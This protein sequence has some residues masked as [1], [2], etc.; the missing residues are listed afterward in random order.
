MK[1]LNYIITETEKITS[2]DPLD[3]DKTLNLPVMRML[4]STPIQIDANNTLVSNVLKSFSYDPES[5]T[6]HLKVQSDLTFSDGSP[7]RTRDIALAISRMISARP[8]F[9]VLKDI[10]GVEAWIKDTQELSTYPSG[11]SVGEKTIDIKLN[12]N[13][14]NPLFRFCLEIFSIIPEKC[15]DLKTN[16]LTCERP[17]S[18]GYYVIEKETENQISF[19]KRREGVSFSEHVDFEELIFQYKKM[20]NACSELISDNTLISG[21]EIG[22]ILSNCEKIKNNF[23]LHWTAAARFGFVLFS[24]KNPVFKKS[25]N[26]AYF[27]VKVREQLKKDHP[28]MLVTQSLFTSILPGFLNDQDFANDFSSVN[29]LDFKDQSFLY[30]E[31]VS[32]AN[33]VIHH[34]IIQTAESLGMKVKGIDAKF[35]SEKYETGESSVEMASSG[36]W[37]QDPVGDLSMFFTKNLHRPLLFVWNDETHYKLLNKIESTTDSKSIN[38]DMKMFNKHLSEESLIAPLLHF[39]RLFITSKNTVKVSFPQAV[40]SPAP[41]QFKF[42]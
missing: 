19:K 33:S 6:I 9:P 15:I 27:A 3:A 21:S 29:L 42:E 16:K 20:E 25:I 28:A 13:H 5:T 24:A 35:S 4:Y 39:R 22:Y 8:T 11:M 40:T 36:F 10:E 31:T 2:F 7:I 17:A 12:R 1:S 41:W 37:A 26:R 32:P 18:S 38:E 30:P 34:A 23:N 14:P